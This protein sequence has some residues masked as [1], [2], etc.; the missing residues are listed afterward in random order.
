MMRTLKKAM[1]NSWFFPRYIGIV[2]I[3]PVMREARSFARRMLDLGC[4]TWRYE[5]I[6]REVVDLYIGLDWPEIKRPCLSRCNR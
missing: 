1:V 5:A 4:G 2:Y 3:E 6:F